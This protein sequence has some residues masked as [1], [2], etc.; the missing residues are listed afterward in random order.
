MKRRNFIIGTSLGLALTLAGK[1]FGKIFNNAVNSVKPKM[2]NK[3]DTIGIIAPGTAVSDPESF[4]KIKEV[5]DYFELRCKFG[6]FLAKGT[7]YKTRSVDERL[8]DLHNMF[9]DQ[10]VKA[11]F[12]IRGGYGSIRLLD[13]IDYNLI[14]AN[15]KIFLGYSDITALHLAISKL[16]GLVT[17]HG[18]VL[19]S[20]FSN[21]T[22]S[23]FRK[24]LFSLDPI[25]KVINDSKKNNVRNLHP[26]WSVTNGKSQ[27]KLTGGNL[28]MICSLMG[29]PY[30]IETDGKI[31]FIED[32]DEEPYRIDRMLTQLRL[33]GKFNKASGII[34]GECSGCSSD[35]LQPSRVWDYT[36][37]EVLESVLGD[38]KIPVVY[39]L[40]FGHTSD[41]LT[42]P[43]GVEAVIDS[44]NQKFE[45]LESGVIA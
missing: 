21:W 24:A 13:K 20:E 30:E 11:I 9:S 23:Y 31:L 18:P 32:V 26:F 7:G 41:Q 42:I 15:P 29:T 4:Y 39:G 44:D 38:L 27:G 25:G 43:I 33:A 3:G 5:M 36:L 22:V 12:C 35:R 6:K 45:I 10:S 34:F 28:T 40:T 1:S 2:L 16:T 37:G 17:F 8:E 14:R 19:I